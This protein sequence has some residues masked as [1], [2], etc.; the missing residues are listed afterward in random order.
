MSF[1]RLSWGSGDLEVDTLRELKQCT[2][3]E[4]EGGEA[5]VDDRLHDYFV[6]MSGNTY[7]ADFFNSQRRYWHIASNLAAPETRKVASM[8]GK[9]VAILDALIGRDTVLAKQLLSEHI[10][11][12]E[13]L[14]EE[15]VGQIRGGFEAG[16]A[17]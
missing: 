5:R 3:L 16:G 13:K 12:Q 11:I 7:M 1:C 9:H 4:R 2:H 8:A 17:S 14:V 6:T 15:R 10:R